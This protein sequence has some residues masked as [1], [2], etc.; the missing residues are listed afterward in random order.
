MCVAQYWSDEKG[1]GSGLYPALAGKLLEM[2][3]TWRM[4]GLDEKLARNLFP[5]LDFA[6][7]IGCFQSIDPSN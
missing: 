1:R 5:A 7:I 2:T 6:K 3:P 4:C